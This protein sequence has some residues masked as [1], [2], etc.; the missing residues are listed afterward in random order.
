M[1]ANYNFN[2]KFGN[3]SVMVVLNPDPSAKFVTIGNDEGRNTDNRTRMCRVY[4]SA[5]TAL[6]TEKYAVVEDGLYLRHTMEELEQMLPEKNQGYAYGRVLRTMG[7]DV[8]DGMIVYRVNW[9]GIR[10]EAVELNYAN[11]DDNAG[12]WQFDSQKHDISGRNQID[13]LQTIRNCQSRSVNLNIVYTSWDNQAF[14]EL[15][16][17]WNLFN[18][19]NTTELRQAVANKTTEIQTAVALKHY[20]ALGARAI[21]NNSPFVADEAYIVKDF[22]GNPVTVE[23]LVGR[24]IKFV[25]GQ[26]VL[27]QQTPVDAANVAS[28][29]Q[30]CKTQGRRILFVDMASGVNAPSLVH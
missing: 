15:E 13:A 8:K 16:A 7:F 25:A 2:L 17:N 1:K 4:A 30:V 14:D 26:V 6:M 10:L 12:Q 22:N 24:I 9:N 27:P 23:E 11:P 29:I 5:L 19:G 20:E 18:A 28:I 21:A 3:K